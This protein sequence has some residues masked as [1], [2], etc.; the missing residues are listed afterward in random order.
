MNS[1]RCASSIRVAVARSGAATLVAL[2]A[3]GSL[4]V[5]APAHA[6][7]SGQN[8][9]VA[10]VSGGSIWSVN[11]DGSQPT[12]LTIGLNPSWSPDGKKL[13]FDDRA[14]GNPDIYSA[15]ADGSNRIRLS[16]TPGYD[17]H[18]SWSPDGTKIAFS[19]HDYSQ[20][21]PHGIFVMDADGSNRRAVTN[22]PDYDPAWS[23]DGSKIAFS[24]VREGNPVS[25]DIF[26]VDAATGAHLTRLFHEG[27]VYSDFPDWSPDGT[28]IVFAHTPAGSSW[29][30]CVGYGQIYVIGADGSNPAALTDEP[31]LCPNGDLTPAWSPDGSTIAF[32][33][34]STVY[35]VGADGTNLRLLTSGLAAEW[36]GTAWQPLTFALINI[37]VSGPIAATDSFTVT[38]TAVDAN[39]HTMTDYNG[40]GTWSSLDGALLPAA[41]TDFVNGVSTTVATI[42]HAFHHDRITVEANGMSGQSNLFEVL[43]PASLNVQ[44]SG[45]VSVGVPFTVRIYARD[46]GRRLISDYQGPAGWSDRSGSLTPTSPARF[47]NGVSTTTAQITVPFHD[48][49]F[50]VTSGGVSAQTGP[51][52]VL[53]PLARIIVSVPD[54][55]AAATPTTRN[56]AYGISATFTVRAT[57]LDA[58]RNLLRTYTGPAT[59][60]SLDTAL[61]PA[62][63]NPFVNGVSTTTATVSAPFRE[64]RITLTSSGVSGQ[65]TGFNIVGPLAQI[66]VRLT[67]PVFHGIPF[68]VRAVALDSLGTIIP[69]YNQTATWTTLSGGLTPATPT[70]FINGTSTTQAT[71][72]TPYRHNHITL[73]SGTTTAHSTTFNVR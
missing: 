52:N 14:G 57:A 44:F 20:N 21:S 33:R 46:A 28:K 25:Q 3:V 16:S 69:T 61:A 40:P 6:S 9:N 51:Y 2:A 19:Y 68:T 5:L 71:I 31:S 15:D 72:T 23:P 22:G 35:L 34:L 32:L 11:P 58:A 43:A 70:R 26:V 73:T 18:P 42:A 39:G 65:S 7:F 67:T 55:V 54:T 38:A 17:E 59:W 36:G 27:F 10:Y 66:I 47:V 24:R 29:P 30:P 60:S 37:V 64:D 62:A 8:G 13:A 63:P 12:Q 53:G 48:D 50:T 49:R 4:F 41:P 1:P 45:P 56:P